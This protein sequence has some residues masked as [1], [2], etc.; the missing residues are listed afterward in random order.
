MK[1]ITR[2]MAFVF[3][4]CFVGCGSKESVKTPNAP[5]AKPNVQKTVADPGPKSVPPSVSETEGIEL[6]YRFV[7]GQRMDYIMSME[8]DND[9]IN[10]GQKTKNNMD[11]YFHVTVDAVEADGSAVI[12]QINDR[13]KLKVKGPGGTITY[14]SADGEESDHPQWQGLRQ[15]YLPMQYAQCTYR[16][17]PSG[18]VSDVKPTAELAERLEKDPS[19]AGILS[20]NQLEQNAFA[21]FHPMPA[22]AVAPGAT[23]NYPR[24]VAMG[25]L[26]LEFVFTKTFRATA[27]QEGRQVV[28]ITE[29]VV[30]KKIGEGTPAFDYTL[31]DEK[32]F[33][34][35]YFDPQLGWLVSMNDRTVHRTKQ[36]AAGGVGIAVE[37]H[38]STQITIQLQPSVTPQKPSPVK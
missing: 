34:Q 9:I 26:K 2:L 30:S 11:F 37:S 21:L 28:D 6:R 7:E 22:E 32:T 23:W 14:D 3:L 4:A 35:E 36:G 24:N 25:P 12:T 19:M 13:F 20:Q 17:A 33:G 31:D 27:E 8:T 10:L 38:S 1:R 18:V 5:A 16:V 15:V 29:T